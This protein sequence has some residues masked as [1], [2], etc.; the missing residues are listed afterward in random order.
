MM[1]YKLLLVSSVGSRDGMSIEL[2]TEDGEQIAE[3]FEDDQ[4][5]NR[6]VRFFV[7]S[8]VPLEAVQW[9][10]SKAEADL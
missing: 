5:K 1:G 10:L 8:P 2:A 4:T 6:T 3:V 9:L 7:D